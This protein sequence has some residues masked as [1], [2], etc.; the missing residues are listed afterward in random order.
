MRATPVPR[1]RGFCGPGAG[2]GCRPRDPNHCS[3]SCSETP[4]SMR[5]RIARS[6]SL[7]S[8]AS[9]CETTSPY[10]TSSKFGPT[11]LTRP[12]PC[13]VVW[14]LNTGASKTTASTSSSRRVVITDEGLMEWE[15]PVDPEVHV[16]CGDGLG[17]PLVLH[18]DRPVDVISQSEE[19]LPVDLGRKP[20]GV[21]RRPGHPDPLLRIV[22]DG[23]R[24]GLRRSCAGCH[25]EQQTGETGEC[26]TE[27][28]EPGSSEWHRRSPCR[29]VVGE[30]IGHE[31]AFPVDRTAGPVR[32][33]PP[34]NTP[35][36]PPRRSIRSSWSSSQP[37]P[38]R[39]RH[40]PRPD[41]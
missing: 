12:D 3:R 32:R 20:A 17:E 6:M 13:R 1:F 39:R 38:Q 36:C 25:G 24:H 14:N 33:L 16:A 11:V 35:P 21:Q 37:G 27:S 19:Q 10:C 15:P 23:G 28:T 29:S 41:R 4:L 22:R 34:A 30:P 2:H 8:S 18:R 26:C 5:S 9:A 31:T 40:Q 7:R